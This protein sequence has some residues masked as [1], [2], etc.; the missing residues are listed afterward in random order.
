MNLRLGFFAILIVLIAGSA[1]IHRRLATAQGLSETRSVYLGGV[2]FQPANLAG[3]GTAS[4]TVS[5]ATGAEV[6]PIGTD[7]GNPVRAVIQVVE[8]NNTSGITYTITPSQLEKLNLNGRGRSSSMDFTFSV[9]SKN[10]RGGVISCRVTLIRLEN[11][12]GVAQ[13]GWQT[14][15]DAVLPVAPPPSPTPTPTPM[16]TPTP[17]VPFG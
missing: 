17:A 15:M 11:A 8:N 12:A 6:P 4:L 3:S 13:M 5:V 9:D 7:N 2:V 14:V 10:M 16:P 1:F